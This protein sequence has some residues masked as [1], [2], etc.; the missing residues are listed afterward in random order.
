M[1]KKCNMSRIHGDISLL[2]FFPMDE[3]DDMIG[4]VNAA[5]E[6]AE[7]S[8]LEGKADV[9]EVPISDNVSSVI[10]PDK[11]DS[12][13][14]LSSRKQDNGSES[15]L[16]VPDDD[17]DHLLVK[18]IFEIEN[19]IVI[20]GQWVKPKNVEN[21]F[22]VPKPV[23]TCSPVTSVLFPARAFLVNLL[24]NSS[25]SSNYHLRSERI[26]AFKR[27]SSLN[28]FRTLALDEAQI[29]RRKMETVYS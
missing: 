6:S 15:V 12:M 9:Q 26:M 14:A 18:A 29:I 13:S 27:S 25:Y 10:D 3:T 23:D 8:N 24:S 28:G 22:L 19:E 16:N 2:V 4:P 17:D 20:R 7:L 21:E 5:T 11:K 1:L